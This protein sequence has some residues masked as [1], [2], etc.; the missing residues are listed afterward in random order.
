MVPAEVVTARATAAAP[1]I[2]PGT[3]HT[4]EKASSPPA[5]A[6]SPRPPA[7]TTVVSARPETQGAYRGVM[8]GARSPQ[9]GTANQVHPLALQTAVASVIVAPLKVNTQWGCNDYR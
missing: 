6:T 8:L 7:S 4:R 2:A 5:F 9:Q 1:A 3:R